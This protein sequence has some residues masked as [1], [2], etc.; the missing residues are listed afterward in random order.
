VNVIDKKPSPASRT[1]P[2]WVALGAS[3]W[4]ADT[5]LRRPLTAV[6]SSIQIVLLE[7]L[8]LSVI[9]LPVFWRACRGLTLRQW[10]AVIGIAWGGSALGSVF[11]TSAVRYGNPTTAVLLQKTQPVIAILLARI[12]LAEQLRPRLWIWLAVAV[13]GAYL[14]SFGLTPPADLLAGMPPASMYALA[15]AALWGGST[16]LGRFA[17]RDIPF[18]R[19]TALRI[20]IASPLLAVLVCVR[21]HPWPALTLV[22]WLLLLALALIPGLAALLIYYRGLRQTHAT[23]AAIAELSFPATAALL[24]WTVFGA[25]VTLVQA[26]GFTL[27]WVAILAM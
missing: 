26:G 1:G 6:L 18:Q 2:L 16:V 3:L 22:Q 25:G 11:F 8:I 23:R 13:A 24:N 17:L 14:V 12:V 7:H 10:S 21:P 15:A 4:G 27:L 20:V 9:L 5:V 19:L